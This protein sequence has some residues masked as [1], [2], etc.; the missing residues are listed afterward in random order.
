MKKI[1]KVL[2]I[3]MAL[4]MSIATFSALSVFADDDSGD[5]KVY[6]VDAPTV[7]DEEKEYRKYKFFATSPADFL[8]S[9]EKLP[10]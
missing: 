7:S 10:C 9:I 1:A 6:V 2:S 8:K 3:I 4:A 5:G